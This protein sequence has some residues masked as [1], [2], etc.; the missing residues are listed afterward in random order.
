MT[1]PTS[2][3]V[4]S[5]S[6]LD[7]LFNAGVLDEIVSG[8]GDTALDRFGSQKLTL[9]GAMKR[10]G[11]EA[12]VAFTTGISV[13]RATQTVTYSG[14]TYHAEPGS[15]PFTTAGTFNGAQWRLV[16]TPVLQLSAVTGTS[17]TS[18][19]IG[20]G[21]KTLTTQ[22]GK[23]WLTGSYVSVIDASNVA[24][25][26][27]GRVTTYDSGTGVLAFSCSS[28][29]GTGTI[30]DWVVMMAPPFGDS[31]SLTGDVSVGRLLIDTVFYA[32]ISGASP[33][34][35][36]DDND[37]LQFDR[38]ANSWYWV[39]GG[40]TVAQINANGVEQTNDA[41]TP[42]GLVRKSQMEASAA[43][44]ALG[45]FRAL[46][47]SASGANA[48][49]AISS[50]AVMLLNGSGGALLV[51]PSVTINSAG[52]G[53][54]GL[55]TG[56][57]AAS[58]WYSVWVISNGT[59]TAG[60]I[61]LSATAPTMPGGY[62]Y[63]ARVGWIRTDSSGNKYPLCFK[64]RGMFAEYVVGGNVTGLPQMASG[65]Q[66]DVSAPTWVSVATGN[67][68][69]PTASSIK[70]HISGAVGSGGTAMVA[71]SNA[72]GAFDNQT[73]PPPLSCSMG[74]PSRSIIVGEITLQASN[75]YFA[76]NIAAQMYCGGWRDNL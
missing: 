16:S 9:V 49:I 35:Y 20:T 50:D 76:S 73:N 33:V 12:P 7:L 60:L 2:N 21:A 64:Q 75:I 14:N 4:P 71:P 58:T 51:A 10:L 11:F 40:V 62:G 43:K 32:S 17:T 28:K 5:D 18:L 26:M 55:D 13:L 41:T 8:S 54:N 38:S 29:F 45:G 15:L 57:L 74:T 44:L 56:S 46:L 67:F 42:G 53:A 65:A 34:I 39:V 61:S 69:P 63:K 59:A 52:A 3:A 47:I 19:L 1:T 37:Y 66:G 22:A 70:L 30:N 72:Y 23:A 68:V 24:N 27:Y 6:P 36:F 48:S 31:V 25:V